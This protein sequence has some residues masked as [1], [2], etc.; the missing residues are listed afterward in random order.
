[1]SNVTLAAIA[2]PSCHC[3]RTPA[4]PPPGLPSIANQTPFACLILAIPLD[5][6]SPQCNCNA[7][8][9]LAPTTA[10]SLRRLPWGGYRI[11]L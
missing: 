7:R 2:V 10:K 5:R 1:V 8:R 6:A 11:T 9:L 3:G 4:A